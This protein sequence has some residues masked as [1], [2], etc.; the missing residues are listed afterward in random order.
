MDCTTKVNIPRLRRVADYVAALC[1]ANTEE[2]LTGAVLNWFGGD[3]LTA[4]DLIAQAHS[5]V[6]QRTGQHGDYICNFAVMATLAQLVGPGLS[7]LGASHCLIAL[8]G[9]RLQHDPDNLDTNIDII[10]YALISQA[11]RD[12]A[13]EGTNYFN[14]IQWDFYGK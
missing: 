9:S 12:R 2:E 3:A 14:Q 7:P 5:V 4:Q 10:G 8:K 11:L 6:D 13:D 1:A